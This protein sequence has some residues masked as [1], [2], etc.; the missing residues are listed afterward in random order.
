[1]ELQ[2]ALIAV[3]SVASGY[4]ALRACPYTATRWDAHTWEQN[5][6]ESGALGAMLF[7]A[8]RG[9]GFQVKLMA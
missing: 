9:R 1:M 7:V 5:F 8:V 2:Q 4:A 3:F 6:F